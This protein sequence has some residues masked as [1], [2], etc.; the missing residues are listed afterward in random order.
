MKVHGSI[1]PA[2][3]PP[4][5]PGSSRLGDA[6][7]C[8]CHRR[9]LNRRSQMRRR[10][11]PFHKERCARPVFRRVRRRVWQSF[12]SASP[13][14]P[15]GVTGFVMSRLSGF[16]H[17]PFVCWGSV[18]YNRGMG[19]LRR[20]FRSIPSVALVLTAFALFHW[21]ASVAR[22][23][24]PI[25]GWAWSETIGWISL[26]CSNRSTCASVDYGLVTQPDGIITGYG[27]S[28]NIGWISA[29][30]ADLAGCPSGPCEA[31]EAADGT[32]SGWLRALSYGGGWGG[33][34]KLSGS[35]YGVARRQVAPYR[36]T[37]WAWSDL[38]LGWLKFSPEYPCAGTAGNYCEGLDRKSRT[39][40]CVETTIETCGYD[41]Q[42][43]NC[44]PPPPP[45]SSLPSGAVITATPRIVRYGTSSVI[46][47]NVSGA[48]SC[49]VTGN[50]NSW[51]GLAG[52][53]TS[54]PITKK[55]KYSLSCN[56]SGGTLTGSVDVAP[57]SVFQEF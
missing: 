17:R 5:A 41:C 54:N 53:R 19:P 11:A 44:I 15:L 33:F 49:S 50:G 13:V 43:A 9:S 24:T 36:T 26:N 2:G 23:Q 22:A 16:Q 12:N 38:V 21:P 8:R 20:H 42:P 28:E 40:Q 3:R 45:T 51:T 27:W 30:A 39:E 7:P 31:R 18:S 4:V 1:S 52:P 25:T 48:T 14:S 37:G 56:G 47:W 32:F 6:G 35:G 57:A 29:N 34:I 46:N 55:V 10:A